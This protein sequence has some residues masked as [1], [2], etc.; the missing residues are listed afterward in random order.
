[1]DFLRTHVGHTQNVRSL[2]L[3]KEER[4]ELAMKIKMGVS[5]DR[6]LDDIKESVALEA[7][8][9][10]FH[11]VKKRDLYNIVRDYNLKR[12]IALESDTSQEQNIDVQEFSG[13]S[14]H[15][16]QETSL[17]IAA[18][19]T[20]LLSVALEIASSTTNEGL[21]KAI[22][23]LEDA[24]EILKQNQV[25]SE[26][27]HLGPHFSNL[28]NSSSRKE[29]NQQT[30]NSQSAKK[31]QRLYNCRLSETTE[32]QNA[33]QVAIDN[34]ELSSQ[35]V[36]TDFDHFSREEIISSDISNT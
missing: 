31:K 4:D 23:H 36:F 33:N 28:P 34:D 13:E 10:R 16:E 32:M 17:S 12:E 27:S 14:V 21:L 1:M 35:V 5:F 15:E 20:G 19:I 26:S 11:L 30:F 8:I 24:I 7:N 6:I 2:R 9:R 25:D 29:E 18:S 3:T 22:P